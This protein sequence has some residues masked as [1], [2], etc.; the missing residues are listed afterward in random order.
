MRTLLRDHLPPSLKDFFNK[1]ESDLSIPQF[2]HFEAWITGIL[3]GTSEATKI[4]RPFSERHPS[5]LTRFMNSEAWNDDDLNKQRIGWAT[6]IMS[7]QYMKYYPLIIDDTINKKY[8]KLLDGAGNHFSH[9]EG[10]VV[11]GSATG[12]F[13]HG[14]CSSGSSIIC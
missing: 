10:R 3:Q 1:F 7:Q 14:S 8:G 2:D 9:M 5:S 4:S 11:W 6:N 12:D 13:T